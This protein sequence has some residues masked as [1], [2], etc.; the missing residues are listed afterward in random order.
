[1]GRLLVVLAGV[2]AH[3]ELPG[4]DQHHLGA[5]LRGDPL[6]RYGRLCGIA[7]RGVRCVDAP[8]TGK[9]QGHKQHR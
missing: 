1:M 5:V 2:A 8:T 7:S 3:D 6:D 9:G 4:R